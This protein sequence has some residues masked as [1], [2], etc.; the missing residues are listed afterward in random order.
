[1]RMKTWTNSRRRDA[2][3]H[4]ARGPPPGIGTVGPGAA[5][6]GEGFRFAEFADLA[7]RSPG[8]GS[9]YLAYP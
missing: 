1:M 4:E 3:L 6:L 8:D 5:D 2:L 9:P 7:V